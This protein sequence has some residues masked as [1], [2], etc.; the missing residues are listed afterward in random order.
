MIVPESCLEYIKL[1]R[2][3]YTDQ[4]FEFKKRMEQE[5]NVIKPFLPIECGSVLDIGCGVG[6][7]DV[8]LNQHY[9][10]AN[11][12]LLDNSIS[13][14]KPI[15][16]YDRGKSYYNSFCATSDMMQYNGVKNFTF[17]DVSKDDISCLR[18]ID[19]IISLLSWGYHYPVRTYIEKVRNIISRH[20]RLIM[21]IRENTNGIDIVNNFFTNMEIIIT[22]NKADRVVAWL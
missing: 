11:F 6:G 3:G 18:N 13:S 9:D 15:Y 22:D 4:R 7:I 5:Y 12:I 2:S 14:E 19:L 1:Q 10:D 21:D 8:L 16:G 20:G 17:M